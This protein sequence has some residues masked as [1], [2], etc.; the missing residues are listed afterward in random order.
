MFANPGRVNERAERMER[1]LKGPPTRRSA[2]GRAR[3]R[4]SRRPV[5]RDARGDPLRCSRWDIGHRLQRRRGEGGRCLGGERGHGLAVCR[6][7]STNRAGPGRGQPGPAGAPSVAHIGRGASC[8]APWVNRKECRAPPGRRTGA[9]PC[10]P[11]VAHA[12]ESMAPATSLPVPSGD[13]A[14]SPWRG[15]PG[16]ADRNRRTGSLARAPGSVRRL[17]DAIHGQ[18]GA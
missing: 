13:P 6:A 2:S 8:P 3:S 11:S 17:L 14:A 4:R 12:E 16:N 5:H 18:P 7:P 9:T 1:R 15:R 10:A